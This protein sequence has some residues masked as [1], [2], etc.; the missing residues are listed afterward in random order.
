MSKVAF[1]C[2]SLGFSCEWALRAGSSEEL[3]DRVREH[4]RCAHKLTDL[5]PELV[6]RVEAGIHPAS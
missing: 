1:A 4:A 5:S 3:L 6:Q 2:A